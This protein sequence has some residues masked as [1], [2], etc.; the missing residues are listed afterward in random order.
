M[1]SEEEMEEQNPEILD[2][3]TKAHLES[4]TRSDS[5]I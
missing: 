4:M 2:G 3:P 1:T 5:L